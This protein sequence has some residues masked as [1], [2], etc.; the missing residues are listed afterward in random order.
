MI[1]AA[2]YL[3]GFY[4]VY[5]VFLSRDTLYGRNRTFILLSAISAMILPLITIR[6][7]NSL[8][9]PVFGKV[10]SEIFISG[11]AANKS[12]WVAGNTVLP[13]YKWLIIIYVSGLI[14]FGLKLFIDFLELAYLIGTQEKGKSHIIEFHGLNTAGFSAFGHIFVSSRLTS[15]EAG[16]IIK[17]EQNHL[18]HHHSAD[19][20]LIELVMLFQWFNP[21]IYFFSRSLRAVHE[22]QADEECINLGISV[23]NYQKLLMNQIFK[24]KIFTITNSFSNPS[25]VKK[26]MIMMTKQRSGSLANIKLLLVLPV[27]ASVMFFISSCSQGNNPPDKGIEAAPPPPPPPPLADNSAD[28][29]FTMVDEFPL[30][31][32]GEAALLNFISENVQYP[33][34]AKGNGTQGKVIV[35][36]AVEKDGSIDKISVLKGV[37]PELDKEAVRVVSTLPSFEKPGIKDGKAVPVWYMVPINYTLK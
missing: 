34:R 32:G 8:E 7:N 17:H 28:T 37:D 26:R 19:I 27:I 10:L 13:G 36:F 1:K 15:E 20:I 16:E 29:V 30:F 12:S 9:V 11:N 6:T 24:S 25:L 2:I 3:A 21:V 31:P 5:R 14:F 18:N 35:R 33:E 23:N 22:Y 4:L